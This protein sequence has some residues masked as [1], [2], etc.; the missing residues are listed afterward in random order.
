MNEISQLAKQR[1]IGYQNL[2]RT[3]ILERLKEE[4][5]NKSFKR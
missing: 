4:S 1:G 3:W 5:S 2:I